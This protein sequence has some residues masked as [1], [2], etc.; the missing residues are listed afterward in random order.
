MAKG[1]KYITIL[2]NPVTQFES[3]F[4]YF[5]INKMLPDLRVSKN[6]LSEFL[7][8]P[9]HFYKQLVSRG[10]EITG[11][12][13]NGMLYDL[14]FE[15]RWFKNSTDISM[16]IKN[17]QQ[18]FDLV[19]IAEYFDESLVLLMRTFCWSLD[20]IMYIKQ[21]ARSS[22]RK[23][24]KSP[25]NV[26]R[27]LTWNDRDYKLYQ[28][29]NQTFWTKIK[30]EGTSFWTDLEEFKYKNK[31]ILNRCDLTNYK[32]NVLS[33]SVQVNRFK[34]GDKV[35]E[36]DIDFCKKFILTE[37]QYL[38]YFRQKYDGRNRAKPDDFIR[39]P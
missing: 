30:N 13:H 16:D 31:K 29:F 35:K 1:A 20:D 28:V 12:M 32:E 7:N 33:T 14:G 18:Q 26:K 37:V 2:R 3:S 8:N 27:I 23:V 6:P 9:T 15:T 17:I 38:Q 4:Y 10:N 25:D 19:L 24:Q 21:N 22:S 36:K 11:L 34:I 5:E 39:W